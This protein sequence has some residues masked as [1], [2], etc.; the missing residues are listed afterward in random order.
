MET[1]SEADETEGAGGGWDQPDSVEE[2]V[3]EEI[4]DLTVEVPEGLAVE[5]PQDVSVE[6]PEGVTGQVPDTATG[7]PVPEAS[8]DAVE[9]VLDQVDQALARLDDGTYGRCLECGESI[10]DSRL[11]GDPTLLACGDCAEQELIGATDRT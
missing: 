3:V 4:E 8:L 10:D 7:A 11:A 1:W 6:V 5:L 9:K 2:V